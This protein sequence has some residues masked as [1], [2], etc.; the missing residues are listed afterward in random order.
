M[1]VRA[2]AERE[3]RRR[4]SEAAGAAPF[5]NWLERVT[6]SYTWTWPY[7]AHIQAQLDRVTRGDLRRLMLFL[8]PRHGKSEMTTVRYPVWRMARQ[9]AFRVCVGCYNQRFAERFGR[10]ARR[11]AVQAGEALSPDLRSVTE[12]ELGNGSV[13]RSAGVGSPPTGEGFDLIVIDDPIKSREEANSAAYRERVW[14]WYKDDLYTRCEPGAAIIIIQTRWHQDDLAGRILASEDAEQWTV[15]S[16]PA[17][18]EAGD[19][20]GRPEA[21]A[22]CP[23]RFPASEL[24]G[25]RRVLG[26]W[27]YTALYQQ[28]PLPEGGGL[29]KREWFQIVD[30]VPA[31]AKRV[32][33]WDKAG[34]A[35]GGDFSSGVK[36]AAAPDGQFYVADVQRGQWSSW[37][38]NQVMRQT[39]ELDG[40]SVAIWVEQEPGSGGK[41]SAEASIRNLV[42]FNVHAEAPTGDKAV[43]AG[44]LAAQAEAGNVKL[45]RGAWNAPYLDE[46]CVFPHGKNDDQVD[47]SSGAF[48]KLA[49][50]QP[51]RKLVTW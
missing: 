24:A 50:P 3:R 22:L 16:L 8:P 34:T 36:L 35:G 11:I 21:E 1:P 20:L 39:A 26:T 10:K 27:A 15:V 38:R 30:A 7:L 49:A 47:G 44:P 48:N 4:Q 45:V 46:L 37:Q 25:I 51:S 17:E 23:E 6:P 14:Q 33:Y 31:Q 41:E 32:R 29:F 28:R 9:P 18:A 42:G 2:I 19:A 5:L 13:F 43:R 40:K 12:W